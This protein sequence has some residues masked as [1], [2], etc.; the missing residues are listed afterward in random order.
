[1]SVCVFRIRKTKVLLP[2]ELLLLEEKSSRD[3]PT[4]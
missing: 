4:D 2:L 1:M 3:D